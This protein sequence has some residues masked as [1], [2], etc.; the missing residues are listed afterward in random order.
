[1]LLAPQGHGSPLLA[2]VGILSALG[3]AALLAVLTRRGP[4][5]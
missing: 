4:A 5:R 1:V 2:L 3:V